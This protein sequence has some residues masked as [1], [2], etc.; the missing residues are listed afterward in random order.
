[1]GVGGGGGEPS[2]HV[3]CCLLSL[4]KVTRLHHNNIQLA[5]SSLAANNNINRHINQ[6]FY[7][8]TLSAQRC[9]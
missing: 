5:T 2:V 3:S 7:R 8:P 9:V 4:K 1:M 6:S